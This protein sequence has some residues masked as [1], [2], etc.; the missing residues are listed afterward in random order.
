MALETAGYTDLSVSVR[1]GF[2]KSPPSEKNILAKGVAF[3]HRKINR[4]FDKNL[5]N[6]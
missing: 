4:Y 6:Q 2:K 5:R 1:E 3:F